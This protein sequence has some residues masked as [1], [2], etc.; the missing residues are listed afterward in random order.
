MEKAK[1][2]V[3]S[4]EQILQISERAKM[5]IPYNPLVYSRAAAYGLP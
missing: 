4:A 1:F 2:D 5:L 3:S